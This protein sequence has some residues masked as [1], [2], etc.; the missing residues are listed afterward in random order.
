VPI[1]IYILAAIFAWF[2][3]SV[4][5]RR[6][7]YDAPWIAGLLM[8]IPIVNV[9]LLLFL[10]LNESPNEKRLRGAASDPEQPDT[11]SSKET[12][13]QCGSALPEDMTSC[14]SCG[15]SYAADEQE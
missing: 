10:V 5:A 3:W 8:L 6:L 9:G 1:L 15:W 11:V 2:C 12:C 13:L 14:A 7:G 4:L